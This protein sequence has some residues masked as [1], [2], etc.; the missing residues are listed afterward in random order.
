MSE[1][2]IEDNKPEESKKSLK[3]FA[4]P[5]N[6]KN[7]NRAGRR[8]GAKGAIPSEKEFQD[9][10]KKSSSEAIEKLKK[11]MR[12]GTENNQLKAAIKLLDATFTVFDKEEKGL[13]IKKKDKDGSET[14]YEVEEKANGTSGNTVVNFKKLVSTEYKEQD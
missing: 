2:N 1:D 5:E 12:D 8:V 13:H 11:I 10:V 7:I 14:E 6:K 9:L 4:N 3:G